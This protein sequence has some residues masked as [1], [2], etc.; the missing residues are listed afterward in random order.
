LFTVKNEAGAL[1]KALDIIGK[2]GFNMRTLRSRPMKELM[3]KY[4]FYIEVEGNAYS[5]EG[6][7]MLEDLEEFCDRLKVVGHYASEL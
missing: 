4:Y 5:K 2:H 7:R 6:R 1:A 3:W